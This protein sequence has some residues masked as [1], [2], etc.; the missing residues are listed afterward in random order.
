MLL[1]NEVGRE[2]TSWSVELG[3]GDLAL[4]RYTQYIDED[5]P[6]PDADGARRRRRRNGARLG[7]GGRGRAD[8]RWSGAPRATRLALTYIG[9]FPDGYRARTAPE[10]G[11]ADIL[12]LCDACR[13]QRPRRPHLAARQRRAAASCASRPIAAAALIPLSDAVPVLENFGF[14]VLEEFPTALAGGQRLHPRFP[15]RGRRRGRHRVDPRRAPARSSAR[16]PT[17]FAAPPRTT[18]STSWSSMPASTRRPV[19]WLRAWF[20]YLRQTGSSFGL[21]TVVDALRR[22]PE[23]DARR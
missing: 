14:R 5:A 3:D 8:R 13:R 18:S 17:C 23:C 22:A 12:R 1:E 2:I 10:E 4:I 11:A 19:V 7:A 6:T 20:R 9:S 15:R 21:V 16:S